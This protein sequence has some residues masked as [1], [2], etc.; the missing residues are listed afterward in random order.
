LKEKILIIGSNGFLGKYIL[1]DLNFF[2]SIYTMNRVE[3]N[4]NKKNIQC[5]ISNINQLKKKISILPKFKYVINLSGQAE[6]SLHSMYKNIF[7]ANQNL[8]SCFNNWKTKLIFFSTILVYG[9][10]KNYKTIKSYPKPLCNYSKIKFKTENL[11]KKKAKDYLIIRLANV[12]DN[13]LK[14]KSLL[15]NLMDNIKNRKTFKINQLNS[16]RNY[17]HVM[18]LVQILILILLKK[19]TYK[20]INIGHQNINNLFMIN[21]FEK[22]FKKSIVYKHLNK[23]SFNDSSVNLDLKNILNGIKYKFNYSVESTLQ[24][25][26]EK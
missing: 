3:K 11:Y 5:D 16:S 15:R 9:N 7:V 26:Y 1:K 14:K 21:I 24:K 20:I 13:K 4:K 19:F 12:Y 18:D 6:K 17:I 10:S 22:I 25:I 23:N 8:I 2:F